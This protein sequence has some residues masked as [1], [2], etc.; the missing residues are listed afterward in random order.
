M[1]ETCLMAGRRAA[2]KQAKARIAPIISHTS[3]LIIDAGG[4][5]LVSDCTDHDLAAIRRQR[6]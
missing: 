3:E 2:L 6:A 1:R 5:W 4:L